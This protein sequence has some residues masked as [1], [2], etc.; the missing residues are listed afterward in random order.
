MPHKDNQIM[1]IVRERKREHD[2]SLKRGQATQT[3]CSIPELMSMNF[4]ME[5]KQNTLLIESL[6][7]CMHSVIKIKHHRP[8]NK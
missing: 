5:L 6:K 7:T 3:P 1:G 4:L 8:Q 2:G